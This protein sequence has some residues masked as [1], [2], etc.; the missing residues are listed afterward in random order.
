MDSFTQVL[1]GIATAELCAGKKL[2]RKTFLYG[3]ILGTLPDLD[4]VVAQFMNPVDGIAIHRGI[5][6]SVLLFLVLSPFLGWLITKIERGKINFSLATKMVFWCLFTHVLLDI[7]TSWGTQIFWPLP[8][9]VALK[10]IFLIDPLYT[11][12]LLIFL[13]LAWRKKDDFLSRKKWVL[14]G[15][16]LSSLYLLITCGLKLYALQQFDNAL[17][18]QNIAYDDLIVKPT[19]FNC[20][21]WNANV[22]AK[23]A[24][25][26]ADYSFF[27]TESITFKKYPKNIELEHLLQGNTDFEKLKEISEGWFIVT[28][29]ENQL[30]F[31][32]L[33]FG[34]LTSNSQKTQFAFSY[35]F[36]EE[37]GVLKAYEVPKQKRDGMAL[38]KNIFE[39]LKGN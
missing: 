1:L 21:L 17:K 5:S 24:Y 6:H 4:V 27:D 34:L 15:I 22:A 30:Y 29:S 35:V 18:T 19:A 32:D 14:T 39:R 28:K 7:L 10:T 16:Y 13:I 37:N 8:D 36:K 38:V 31:N 12:P 26:L 23:E 20:I 2:Q 3:A 33:R 11:I 25:F 9:R